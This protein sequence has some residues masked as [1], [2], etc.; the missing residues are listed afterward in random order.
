MSVITL[1]LLG[2]VVP[3]GAEVEYSGLSD[4]D[5]AVFNLEA[6]VCE[7]RNK[8][9]KAGAHL[10]GSPSTLS[11]F[12]C[13]F[14][15]P[16]GSFANNHAMDWGWVGVTDTLRACMNRGVPL[17]G[18]GKNLDDACAPLLIDLNG[19]SLGFLGCCESE[20]GVAQRDQ[21]GVCPLNPSL[22]GRVRSLR[23][24]ADI[25][26]VSVHGGSELCPWPFPEHQMMMRALVD[27]GA[28]IVHG[29]HPHVP[30]GY[31]KYNDSVIF[32]S[33]GNLLVD[34]KHWEHFP[35]TL[36]SIAP[37]ITW[38]D[39]AISSVQCDTAVC[40]TNTSKVLVRKSTERE[41]SLHDDYLARA[42][43]PLSNPTILDGL[44]KEH[45]ARMYR[46]IYSKYLLPRDQGRWSQF[47]SLL[48]TVFGRKFEPIHAIDDL[49]WYHLFSC[50]S[51]R[52]AIRTGLGIASGEIE[53]IPD[54]RIRNRYD[55]LSGKVE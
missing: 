6:A 12:L 9:P 22:L 34:P 41:L 24:K 36:W 47:I 23:K 8:R 48:S 38:S 45:S 53:W 37:L 1:R 7:E 32:Y 28:T 17:F 44:A 19:V 27:A 49:L 52:L 2:D 21:P 18:V 25:V 14:P 29:H 26:V 4:G 55:E 16:V 51:H 31:E 39:G 43:E 40:G 20:Y 3:I 35:N 33:L 50:E 30:Q 11:G 42:N 46:N 54:E 13:S 10:V 15:N 5:L